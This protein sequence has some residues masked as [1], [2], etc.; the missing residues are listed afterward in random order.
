MHKMGVK[1]LVLS[2]SHPDRFGPYSRKLERSEMIEGITE[3]SS[4][5]LNITLALN[6]QLS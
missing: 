2:L 4:P 3:M 5:T 6:M 1:N